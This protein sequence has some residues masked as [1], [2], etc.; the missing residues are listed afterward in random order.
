MVLEFFRRG[1]ENQLDTIESQV[2]QMLGEA[3]HTFDLA[4]S[5]LLAGASATAVDK[6]LHKTDRRINKLERK[7]RRELVVHVSVN[8][9]GTDVPMVLAFMAIAKDIERIGDYSKNIW[10]LAAQGVDLSNGDDIDTLAAYRDRIS[11]FISQTAN[12][13]LNRATDKAWDYLK[14]ADGLLSEFDERINE[15][16]TSERPSTY[17]VP[18]ALYYRY[19]KRIT[20]HLMNVLTALTMPVDRLAYYDEDRR[21]RDPLDK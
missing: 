16:V 4:A 19:L 5:T 10:D 14:E 20:A 13:F 1:S 18:R 8:A 7:I 9:S 11:L 6:D 15:L 2:G 17:G 3:R 21:D 12:T